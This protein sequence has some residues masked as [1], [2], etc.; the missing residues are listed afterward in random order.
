MT[1]E[2][3][4]NKLISDPEARKK[5]IASTAEYYKSIG[6]P[7]DHADLSTLAE[8]LKKNAEAGKAARPFPPFP[9][10]VP[11]IVWIPISKE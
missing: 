9:I 10:V 1:K 2:E 6:L 8:H 5:F 3:L 7:A 11:F 4:K